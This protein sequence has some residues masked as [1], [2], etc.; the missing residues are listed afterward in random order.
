M[1]RFQGVGLVLV[2]AG[3]MACSTKSASDYSTS[4]LWA[5]VTAT[6]SGSGSTYLNATFRESAASLTFIQLTTDDKLTATTGVTSQTMVE[7]SLLGAVGYSTSF[8]TNVGGTQFT[9]ALARTKDTGAPASV[10]T[11]PE[12]FDLAAPGATSISRQ[13]DLALTWLS[14]LSEDPMTVTVTGTC[15]E[16]FRADVPFQV[17]GYTIAAN[18]LR[19]RTPASASDTVPDSCTA[20]AIV[21]RTRLGTLDAHYKGGTST[22][23]Q[24]RTFS[25]TSIL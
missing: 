1:G 21:S 4:Q 3:S 8:N 23:R 7:A 14:N 16:T 25:F 24:E 6:A 11:L 2:A 10:I 9:V 18:A 17:L 19:K 22:G 20:T 15:L 12:P 5:D 13:Q